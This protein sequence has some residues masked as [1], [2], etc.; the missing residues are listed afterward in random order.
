M[1]APLRVAGAV[2]EGGGVGGSLGS[3]LEEGQGE[4][5]DASLG[6]EAAEAE[7]EGVGGSLGSELEEGQGEGVGGSLGSELEEGQGEGVGAS[8]GWGGAE[9]EGEGV[10][11]SETNELEE[12]QGEGVSVSCALEREEREGEGER[13]G[14]GVLPGLPEAERALLLLCAAEG[15]RPLVSVGEPG[16]AP[17]PEG[18]ALA[19]R[20]A[21]GGALGE[22]PVEEVEECREEVEGAGGC[23]G[24]G[25]GEGDALPAAL[26]LAPTLPCPLADAGGERVMDG[27]RAPLAL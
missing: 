24:R 15:E 8:L 23:V 12:G 26:A 27:L 16:V 6:W 3:E 18:G 14:A 7:G 19:V 10:D 17:A 13:E 2:A 20:G 9:A 4:G 11:A 21:L 22:A 1:T 25:E 5:V